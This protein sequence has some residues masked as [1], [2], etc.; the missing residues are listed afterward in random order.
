MKFSPTPCLG[1][2]AF[3]K[4]AQFNAGLCHVSRRKRGVILARLLCASFYHVATKSIVTLH[5][6]FRDI[7]QQRPCGPCTLLDTEPSVFWCIRWIPKLILLSE[8]LINDKPNDFAASKMFPWALDMQRLPFTSETRNLQL[9]IFLSFIRL[10]VL[11]RFRK[12]F[13]S[14]F[15]DFPFINFLDNYFF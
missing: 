2:Q 5:E 15:F 8:K 6:T 13:Q 11:F 1:D 12:H 4:Q 9:S 14:W 3:D 10:T 7:V